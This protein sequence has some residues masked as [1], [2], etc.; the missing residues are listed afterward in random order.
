MYKNILVPL[1]MGHM[2]EGQAIIEMACQHAD[3]DSRIVLLNVVEE[4]PSWAAVN[5][6]AGMIE[7]S[8]EEAKSGLQKLAPDDGRIE[9][10]VSSGHSYNTILQVANDMPSDLII[11]ASH[12]PQLQDYFLGST[13]AKVVRHAECSVLVVR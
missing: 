13:A 8:M 9:V 2:P 1:D 6:P 11:V 3:E 7:Q 4:I 10:Q 5:L 12:R